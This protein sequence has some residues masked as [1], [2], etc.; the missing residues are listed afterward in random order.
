MVCNEVK[1]AMDSSLDINKIRVDLKALLMKLL[2]TNWIMT[3]FSILAERRDSI[4]KPFETVG[5]T[6]QVYTMNHH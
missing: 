6:E 2:H 3:T 5:V 1:E 4:K